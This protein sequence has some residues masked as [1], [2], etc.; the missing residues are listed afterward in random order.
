MNK[1]D[2]LKKFGKNVKIER[3][4]KDLTREM[5]AEKMNVSVHYLSSIELE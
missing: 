3:V 5:L 1:D 4:K 2:L